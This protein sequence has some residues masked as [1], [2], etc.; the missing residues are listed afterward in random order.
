M[1][2]PGESTRSVFLDTRGRIWFGSEYDGIAV[3]DDSTWKILTEK[4]G[5]AGNEVKTMVQDNEGVYWLGTNGGLSRISSEVR[6]G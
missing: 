6:I 1:G 3:R 2:L 5:L 4:E